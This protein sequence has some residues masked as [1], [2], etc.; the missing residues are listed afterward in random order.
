MKLN[1]EEKAHTYG[2]SDI[3][4]SSGLHITDNECSEMLSDNSSLI[5]RV[6]QMLEDDRSTVRIIREIK[7]DRFSTKLYKAQA[8]K[9][10]YTH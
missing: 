9:E 5:K 3:A 1:Y 10:L 6:H 8:L 2:S 7:N 4:N